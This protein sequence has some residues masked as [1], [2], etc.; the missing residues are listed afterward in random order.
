MHRAGQKIRE[1]REAHSPPL[2]AGEF[3]ET[4]G[5]PEKWPSRTVYGWETKGKIPRPSVQK[6][7]AELGI[8]QPS[9]WIEPADA[10]TDSRS[11]AAAV[12][13]PASALACPACADTRLASATAVGPAWCMACPAC[14][15]PAPAATGAHS[16][17]HADTT[18]GV[19]TSAATAITLPIRRQHGPIAQV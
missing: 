10:T 19:A 17:T 7:L 18:L 13:P 16:T 11:V 15:D 4:Y 5:A 12:A 9:D 3:G 2:S 6:R 14:A 1:W 8:C